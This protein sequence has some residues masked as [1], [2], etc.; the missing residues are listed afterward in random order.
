MEKVTAPGANDLKG[1]TAKKQQQH[2][3][4]QEIAC[5]WFR[6]FFLFSLLVRGMAWR[7]VR[8]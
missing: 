8:E 4:I 6:F 1:I 3:K 5:V 7:G 2:N